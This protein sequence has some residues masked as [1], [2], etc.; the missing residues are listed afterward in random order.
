MKDARLPRWR[1]Q[2][3]LAS[4]AS[5]EAERLS[6]IRAEP[7]R[8]ILT[9]TLALHVLFKAGHQG[10]QFAFY[11]YIVLTMLFMLV[12]TIPLIV[13]FFTKP[14]P[15]DTL[16]DRDEI[17]YESEHRAFRTSHGRYMEQLSAGNLIAV[18]RN[19]RLEHA[20][21]D[22]VEHTRAAREFL[23]SLIEMEKSFAEKMKFEEESIGVAE[24]DKR[25]ALEAIKRRFYDDL[26]NGMEIF[27][28]KGR[29]QP[30]V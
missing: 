5:E 9:Q 23:D 4:V 24:S 14:G 15:Y 25:A 11:T 16:V 20:L 17:T 10:G 19:Q 8:D 13:K 22:G 2:E 30:D 12:D 6:S 18:T 29:V 1:V 26:H 27:F 7:R 21:V 28:S 3:E